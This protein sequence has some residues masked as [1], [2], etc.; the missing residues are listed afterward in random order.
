MTWTIR[1][2]SAA[3]DASLY[4]FDE[5]LNLVLSSDGVSGSSN[6][7]IAEDQP[8]PLDGADVDDLSRGSAGTLDPYIGTQ[9]LP[10]GVYYVAVTNANR[11]PVE[12]EQYV[13]ANPSNPLIRLEPI[14]SI[15]RIAE[16]RISYTGGSNIADGPIVPKLIDNTEG[17]VPFT[18]SDVTLFLSV[19]GGLSPG[20]VSNIQTVDPFSGTL[21]TRLGNVSGAQAPF[22]GDIAMRYDGELVSLSHSYRFVIADDNTVGNVLYID[23][24][25]ADYTSP[26]DDGIQT[27]EPTAAGG[28]TRIEPQWST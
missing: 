6:S 15:V 27:W 7:N 8:K 11:M 5:G 20:W 25:T 1:I 4:V 23:T 17:V 21:E 24:G 3:S 14:N 10:Q 13:Q 16:D 28:V 22:I 26:G 19:D 9:S 2:S 18:L 12:L